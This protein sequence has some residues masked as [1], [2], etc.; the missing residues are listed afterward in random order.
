MYVGMA[1][2]WPLRGSPGLATAPEVLEKTWLALERCHGQTITDPRPAY[3][4]LT[5]GEKVSVEVRW[6]VYDVEAEVA[7]LGRSGVPAQYQVATLAESRSAMVGESVSHEAALSTY[8]Q[9]GG[10]ARC[11]CGG[12]AVGYED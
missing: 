11:R 8:R 2:R 6:G 4:I 7:A 1:G 10:A 9:S 3:S 12:S 5:F